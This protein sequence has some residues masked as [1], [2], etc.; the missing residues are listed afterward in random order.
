MLI[1]LGNMRA[2]G[3]RTPAA[4]SLVRRSFF[5]ELSQVLVNA[6]GGKGGVSTGLLKNPVVP[7]AFIET[8]RFLL[9]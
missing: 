6:L 4:W 1:A 7:A 2:N 9:R 3:V 8:H 5:T